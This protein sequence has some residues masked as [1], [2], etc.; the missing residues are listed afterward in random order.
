MSSPDDIS[1][2]SLDAQHDK[3]VGLML[4]VSSSLMIGISF[5]ITKKGL[6]DSTSRHG[7]HG[8]AS[9]QYLFLRNPIWLLGML[10]MAAGEIANFAAY[11]FAPAILVTPLGALSVIIGA[12]LASFFLHEKLGIVG[13]VGCALCLIGS[14]VIVIHAPEDKNINSVDEIL[15]YALQPAFMMYSLFVLG[16]STFMIYRVVP[17]YG[18]RTPIVNISICSFVGSITVMASKGFGIALKLTFAGSNQLTHPSTYVFAIMVGVCIVVQMNYFN[19]A[20]DIFSTNVVMPI[21]YVMF[22]TA[23]ITASVI[24]F[25]G[26]NTTST[27]N[28]V[29]LFCGFGTIFSGVLLL[30]NAQHP[31]VESHGKGGSITNGTGGHGFADRRS[32]RDSTLLNAGYDEESLGLTQ[33]REED[34]DD[35]D[36]TEDEDRRVRMGPGPHS[37][38]H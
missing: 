32:S 19:K 4:A 7:G 5:V 6:I 10:T 20:L 17:K 31:A 12:V 8:S 28:V 11:S 18:N 27:V 21:Y 23:T 3:Y 26:F 15:N 24:L 16:F 13:K 34:E 14:V 25:Q 9:D 33:L 37:H 1:V 29:S 35:E 2:S 36:L 38:I 30:N 22:T